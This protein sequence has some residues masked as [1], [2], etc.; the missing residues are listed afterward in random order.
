MFSYQNEIKLEI[1]N[2]I[3]RRN[4]SIWKLRN[5]FLAVSRKQFE[6]YP[7]FWLNKAVLKEKY[8]ALNVYIRKEGLKLIR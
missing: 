7:N 8:T 6:R 1:N 2:Q 3:F 4:S 5:A